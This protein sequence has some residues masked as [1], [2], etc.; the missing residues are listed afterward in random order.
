[1]LSRRH[2]SFATASTTISQ[3]SCSDVTV[4]QQNKVRQSNSFSST[5]LQQPNSNVQNSHSILHS[6]SQHIVPPAAEEEDEF[7]PEFFLPPPVQLQPIKKQQRKKPAAPKQP[8]LKLQAKREEKIHFFHPSDWICCQKRKCSQ[9]NVNFSM[10]TIVQARQSYLNQSSHN[11]RAMIM[12]GQ[13]LHPTMSLLSNS[14]VSSNASTLTMSSGSSRSEQKES[15]ENDNEQVKELTLNEQVLKQIYNPTCK[16]WYIFGKRV[17]STFF[18]YV[19]QISNQKMYHT[20]NK[21]KI[22]SLCPLRSST[23]AHRSALLTWFDE[24]ATFYEMMPHQDIVQFPFL[25]R[26][27]LYDIYI[28]EMKDKKLRYVAY[29]YF[30]ATWRE[31][32]RNYVL[33]KYLILAKCDTCEQIRTEWTKADRDRKMLDTL[34]KQHREHIEHVKKERILY[35]TKR[36]Y[37]AMNPDKAISI[38]IDGADQA[39]FA[40][41]HFAQ[42]TKT[43]STARKNKQPITGVL[44][45]GHGFFV[46]TSSQKWEHGSNLTIEVLQ[47]T[48]KKLEFQYSKRNKML[49]DQLL[50][51]FDNC[52]RENKNQ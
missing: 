44:V 24:T 34:T 2:S 16:Q 35:Q 33:R 4:N 41:P 51:Q 40:L 9:D 32:R 18:K 29:S 22:P 3:R 12:Y 42:P 13:Q 10:E 37:A 7:P 49:P 31:E 26:K 21:S 52:G 6:P 39:K 17:C 1:M 30:L 28:E 47:R 25:S 14:S 8:S 46:Y 27:A 45:H 23:A 43:T 50:L 11:R 36:Q 5:S 15:K 19:F 38:I 20:T 48:L